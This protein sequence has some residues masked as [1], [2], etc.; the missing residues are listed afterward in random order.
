[1]TDEERA[2]LL[3]TAKTIAIVG[4]SANPEKDSYKVADYLLKQGYRVIPVNPSAKTILGLECR[5][6]LASIGEPVDIVDVF[7]RS[8]DALDVAQQC[9]N[10]GNRTIWYQLGTITPMDVI[11]VREMGLGL[12]N[13]SCIMREHKR[14]LG[15]K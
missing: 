8:E 9:L 6:D 10:T 2:E 12:I 13:E 4:M 15:A 7:R 14:L 1:M 3:I 11:N 5:P